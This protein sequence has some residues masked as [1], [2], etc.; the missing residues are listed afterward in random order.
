MASWMKARQTKYTAYASVYLLVIV[1]ILSAANFLAN[2][3]DKSYDSTANKQFSL[4]DQTTKVVKNLKNDVTVS[5]FDETTKFPQG[6]DLLDRYSAL[7]PK[8][9]VEYVD[10]VKKPQLARAAGVREM[11]TVVVSSG[12]RKEEAKA[13]TEEDVTGA[14]VRAVKSGPRTACFLSGSGEHS[15]DDTGNNGFST[16]KEALEHNNYK[17]QT[18]NLSKPAVQAPGQAPVIGQVAP[19]NVEIPKN[20]TV[21]VVGGPKLAYSAAQVN[22]IKTYVE[23][24]GRALIMLDTPLRIGQQEGVQNPDLVK[25]LADWGVTANNDLALDLSGLGRFL[26]LGPEVAIIAAYEN[27]PIVRDFKE[28]LTAIP[29]SRTFKI[30]GTAKTTVDKLLATTEN[31]IAIDNAV[32]KIDPTKGVKGPLVLAA[33]G[34]Y[35][36]GSPSNPGRFVVYGSSIWAVNSLLGSGAV[37]NRDLALNTFNWLSSDEDLIS[38]HPKEPE[39]RRLNI[40][41]DRMS[42]V[43]WWSVVLIPASMVGFGLMVWWR[44]R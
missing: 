44:R 10:P 42:L 16:L 3:Y 12:T 6:R 32:G 19:A 28:L 17:T 37:Q 40:T 5:Y 7:S 24:G 18:E 41:G 13:L 1:A 27:Q 22:A 33:A 29:L 30:A 15:T 25:L 26:D 8:L 31:S 9:K 43:F 20:C 39:D 34:S 35:N 23:G 14:L 21:L 2:R 36:T 38:I 11:G 4:S